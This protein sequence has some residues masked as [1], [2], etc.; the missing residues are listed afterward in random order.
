MSTIKV[1]DNFYPNTETVQSLI[2]ADLLTTKCGGG[3]R[4]V[5]IEH[6]DS[7]FYKEFC[8]AIYDLHGIVDRSGLYVTTYF[9]EHEYNSIDIFNSGM[10]HI[11]GNDPNKYKLVLCG[12]LFLTL[13]PDPSTGASFWKTKDTVAW[14]QNELYNRTNKNYVLPKK[15]YDAGLIDLDEFRRQHAEYH[16]NFESTTFVDNVYNRLVSWPAGTLHGQGKMTTKMPKRLNQY[17]FVQRI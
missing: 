7:T 14:D 4:S 16:N 13:D 9:M 11:D 1:I 3:F 6:I 12:Q 10:V 5:G 17:F 15:H 8:S 2:T